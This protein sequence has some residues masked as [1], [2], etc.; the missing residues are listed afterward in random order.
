MMHH[1]AWPDVASF[2]LLL[3]FLLAALGLFL[4]YMSKDL[5]R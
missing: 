3:V 4:H 1:W 5:N 2:G